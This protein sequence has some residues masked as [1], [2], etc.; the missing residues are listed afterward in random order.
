MSTLTA[1]APSTGLTVR[2]V[3]K[4]FGRTTVLHDFDLEIR[5]GEMISLLGP[6]GCGKTTALRIIAGLES[7]DGGQVFLGDRDV[8]SVPTN[9]RDLGMVFQSYSLFPHLD[10]AANTAFGLGMRRVDAA[11]RRTRTAEALRLVGLEAHAE[12]YPHE[13]SGGQQQR[14]ALARALVTEPRLLLLDEPL[15]ALDAKVRVQLRDQIRQIQL[16]LGITTVF[17][18]H[19]QEEALAVSDRIAVMNEGRVEQFDTPERLYR[20][21]ATSAVAAFIGTSLR[22]PVTVRDNTALLFGLAVALQAP[23]ADGEATV[24]VR[25]E[26]VIVVQ[27]EPNATVL[28]SSFLGATRR[29]LLRTD[30]GLELIMQHGAEQTLDAEQRVSVSVRPEPVLAV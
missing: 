15:S 25:P 11:E 6:S 7:P 12:R 30:E 13:L 8:V 10:V 19:D 14:V 20:T 17:V 5:P 16:R 1:S 18:T 2:T 24:L 21:P 22:V 26:N 3:S 27:A 23:R 9:R 4:S 29:T 28:S